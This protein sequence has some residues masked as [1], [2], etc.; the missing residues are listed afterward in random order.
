M[1]RRRRRTVLGALTLVLATI[2]LAAAGIVRTWA[3]P[4]QH[5]DARKVGVL[6][7]PAQDLVAP[8][9][10]VAA[11]PME[12]DADRAPAIA[13]PT[14]G[15]RRY[16]Y[17]AGRSP[18][19]GRS[20]QLMRFRVAV[21]KDI[22][23][24]GPQEFAAAALETLAA[25]QGWTSAGKWRFQQVSAADPYDFV[26]YL[27]TPATRDRLCAMGFDQYTS[28]RQGERVVINVA[29]W[30]YGAQ[31]FTAPLSLYRTYV[32][33]HEVGHRLG[34]GHELC[35][36]KGRPAPVMQ[37]QTLGLHGCTPSASAYVDG[38]RYAGPSGAYEDPVP[39]T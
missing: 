34:F 3:T 17:A 10:Q 24:I 19:V 9:S 14:A 12:P 30:A 13:F 18:V 16:A 5:S 2:L 25:P 23:G 21:E 26:L 36:A 15:S 22:T 27:A 37:Q 32:I 31:A 1:M 20:G 33:S 4:A 7:T 39:A 38:R 29:R 35:P 6:S 11:A 28:C 8:P